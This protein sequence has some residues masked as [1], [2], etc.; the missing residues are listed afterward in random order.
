MATYVI[1]VRAILLEMPASDQDS[2][3]YHGHKL[4]QMKPS[5]GMFFNAHES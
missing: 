3:H 5:Y 4:S 1:V 2:V